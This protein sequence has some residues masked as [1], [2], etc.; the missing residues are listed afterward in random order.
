MKDIN[1]KLYG[2]WWFLPKFVGNGTISQRQV[3]KDTEI[4]FMFI[5][6]EMKCL[7]I[8]LR[9]QTGFKNLIQCKT[10]LGI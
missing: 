6:N 4:N 9:E 8:Q 10:I 5:Q 1:L 3:L 7:H 2:N